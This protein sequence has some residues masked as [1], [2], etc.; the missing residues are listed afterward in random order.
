MID[1]IKDNQ[2]YLIC[3]VVGVLTGVGRFDQRQAGDLMI[4]G[5]HQL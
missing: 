2:Q 3:S 4:S 1:S 5:H